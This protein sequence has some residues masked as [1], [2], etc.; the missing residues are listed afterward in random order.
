MSRIKSI[1]TNSVDHQTSTCMVDKSVQVS[2][3]YINDF[4]GQHNNCISEEM[5][6]PTC[7]VDK[8]HILRDSDVITL[9]DK[10]SINTNP[11][12]FIDAEQSDINCSNSLFNQERLG[13]LEE[14]VVLESLDVNELTCVNCGIRFDIVKNC[15]IHEE[16]C[17]HLYACA[18]CDVQFR[19]Y[20]ELMSHI[21]EVHSDLMLKKLLTHKSKCQT[22]PSNIS[23]LCKEIVTDEPQFE[24]HMDTELD[25]LQ[26]FSCFSCKKTFVRS[27]TLKRHIKLFHTDEGPLECNNLHE[28]RSNQRPFICTHCDQK[29]VTFE[30]LLIHG[31]SCPNQVAYKC[32]ECMKV[33][34]NENQLKEHVKIAHEDL[35]TLMGA[36]CVEAVPRSARLHRHIR[37]VHSIKSPFEC[38]ECL[39]AFTKSSALESHIKFAHSSERLFQC[40]ECDKKFLLSSHLKDHV[41]Q[42]HTNIRPFTCR[43]CSYGFLAA[44]DC[45]R[46]E[47]TCKAANKVHSCLHCGEIFSSSLILKFHKRTHSCGQ[48]IPGS[49]GD[50]QGL[51][52]SSD[53]QAFKSNQ[54]KMFYKCAAC[55]EV[56]RNVNTLGEHIRTTHT[57]LRTFACAL[58][59]KSFD[60][61]DTLKRHTEVLH[62]DEFLFED[63]NCEKT[64]LNASQ[65]NTH[66]RYTNSR[67]RPYECDQCDKRFLQ[68][69]HL[70]NHVLQLHTNIRPYL[71]MYCCKGFLVIKDCKKHELFC[72]GVRPYAC[73]ECDKRFSLVARLKTHSRVHGRERLIACLTDDQRP[74][75]S[76]SL[77]QQLDNFADQKTFPCAQCKMYF[78]SSRSMKR[79]VKHVHEKERLFECTV[80]SKSFA[81]NAGLQRHMLSHTGEKPFGCNE[82]KQ[83]FTQ[84]SSLKAHL[85]IHKGERPHVCT[86]CGKTFTQSSALRSHRAVHRREQTLHTET[87]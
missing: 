70:K 61:A 26:T 64:V 84:A 10:H 9:E 14:P 73:L 5:S 59:D 65:L 28:V 74:L 49:T 33:F 48:L 6:R 15:Q 4:F 67:E 63:T 34:L 45:R 80:C 19:Y 23:A 69:G 87:A 42:L 8:K 30:K 20:S 71:C 46:H 81:I 3:D 2:I 16:T 82:C 72:S 12:K 21:E 68:P 41:M 76:S 43:H 50:Q 62:T 37:R 57:D 7:R 1:V 75:T 56:F 17:N 27:A 38:T 54:F 25:G 85:L 22:K 53:S 11:V 55:E 29:F 78:T 60:R 36:T 66:P 86:V 83:R 13:N 51:P 77:K 47:A 35:Q 58:C 24:E 32:S 18:L 52:S 79:H 39:K 31:R 40:A 44:K